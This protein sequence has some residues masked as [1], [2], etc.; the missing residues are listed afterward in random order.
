[1][2]ALHCSPSSGTYRLWGIL[3]E[4]SQGSPRG[5][6]KLTWLLL[7][8]LHLPGFFLLLLPGVHQGL[9]KVCV[10]VASQVVPRPGRQPGEVWSPVPLPALDG[11]E[12][13]PLP[14]VWR[15]G[16]RCPELGGCAPEGVMLGFYNSMFL[17]NWALCLKGIL[18]DIHLPLINTVGASET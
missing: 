6:V 3:R 5:V 4:H 15:A 14:S 17:R 7:I 9:G 11:K 10:A 2:N 13:L 12:I 18:G 16:V 8:S 1:M